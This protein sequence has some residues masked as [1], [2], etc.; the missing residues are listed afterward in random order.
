MSKRKRRLSEENPELATSVDIAQ[1]PQAELERRHESLVQD[2]RAHDSLEDPGA[3]A[4]LDEARAIEFESWSRGHDRAIEVRRALESALQE[5][6]AAN[7]TVDVN[8]NYE[9]AGSGETRRPLDANALYSF[10]ATIARSTPLSNEQVWKERREV[11]LGGLD[12]RTGETFYERDYRR[13]KAERN[14]LVT[15]P[16]LVDANWGVDLLA[17]GFG[18]GRAIIKGALFA[19][20]EAVQEVGHELVT[21]LGKT[22]ILES[23]HG[24]PS[25]RAPS[26]D[27]GPLIGAEV[28]TQS[29]NGT[30]DAETSVA[31]ADPEREQVSTLESDGDPTGDASVDRAAAAEEEEQMS[32]PAEPGSSELPAGVD[33]STKQAATDWLEH[34]STV[35]E[36]IDLANPKAVEGFVEQ[37]S[38]P[39]D[40][41]PPEEVDDGKFD[42][43]AESN[44][45]RI[46]MEAE[47]A[48]TQF[49]FAAD[50]GAIVSEDFP[51]STPE[52][53][54][55]SEPEQAGDNT[56]GAGA[57][58]AAAPPAP[59]DGPAGGNVLFSVAR[60]GWDAALRSADATH[61]NSDLVS[62]RPPQWVQW[63]VNSTEA[64]FHHLEHGT[65]PI[66]LDFYPVAIDRAPVIEGRR[67]TAT[68]TI[69]YIRTHFD[70][71]IDHDHGHFRE[72]DV[73]SWAKWHSG[74]PT[75][76]KMS[77]QIELPFVPGTEGASVVLTE[78][79]PTSWIFSTIYS[80]ADTEH[81]VS[82][83]REFGIEVQPNGSMLF[84]TR[85]AD[86]ITPGTQS[87]YTP[88]RVFE[89]ADAFWKGV[90]NKIGDWV[91][92]HGGSARIGDSISERFPWDAVAAESMNP[93]LAWEDLE[94][95]AFAT[96]PQLPGETERDWVDRVLENLDPWLSV[97]P[98]VD[99]YTQWKLDQLGEMPPEPVIVV[100]R[101]M[102]D[103]GGSSPSDA[104]M[105]FDMEA[106]AAAQG[107]DAEADAAAGDFDFAADSGAT[108]DGHDESSTDAS[109]AGGDHD[110]AG[111]DASPEDFNME[112]DAA[113]QG[114]D[115]AADGAGSAFD[116][117]ADSGAT[118]G[119]GPADAA[120]AAPGS[121]PAGPES[122]S[123]TP[124]TAG[125]SGSDGAAAGTAAPGGQGGEAATSTPA[126]GVAK[127]DSE[128]DQSSQAEEGSGWDMAA[129]A[130]M[131]QSESPSEG[132][133]EDMA[134]DAGS[135]GMSVD[136]QPQQ[137]ET[138]VEEY[139]QRPDAGTGGGG[140]S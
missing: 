41:E 63:E 45:Q 137:Q 66:N 130:E 4:L 114:F 31:E 54:A 140:G 79:T 76:A 65:G 52:P 93:T 119:A 121:T 134:A 86:R 46:D 139:E 35:P 25:E 19:S 125:E 16:G 95:E 17:G 85:G 53:A 3:Q 8:M 118:S 91:N 94:F 64:R 138:P 29:T 100:N 21:E 109:A 5:Q 98:L 105:P 59:S 44:R 80:G 123:G 120:D 135:S 30:S 39:G 77:F 15:E 36:E 60:A 32:L 27:L 127:S 48:G 115:M 2:A 58:P 38:V 111:A 116:F 131:S 82:G 22:V 122:G 10:T 62:F 57:A 92:D 103:S 28:D 42:V 33:V 110:T 67:L 128:D 69:D 23:M 133:S 9:S 112:A 20:R 89:G 13:E 7:E 129:D 96:T 132:R 84:Y 107:L 87:A 55:T 78:I 73:D 83:N 70:R 75:G 47:A 136:Q 104:D 14:D 124:G 126:H 113:A 90:Q 24:L 108:E 37:Q 81:P 56:A 51:T 106:D 43:E 34:A 117:A 101:P 11:F 6:A 50:S 99:A 74:D 40:D 12:V 26:G 88:G 68:E 49:D 102:D 71:F 61:L 18:M 97:S 72:V 1:L